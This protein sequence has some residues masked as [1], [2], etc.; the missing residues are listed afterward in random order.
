NRQA[1]V[2]QFQR[3][4]ETGRR[5]A[6]LA[7]IAPGADLAGIL[8]RLA[9]SRGAQRIHLQ[10]SRRIAVPDCGRGRITSYAVRAETAPAP[11]AELPI[12]FPVALAFVD[13]MQV[14]PDPQ[15]V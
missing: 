3:T 12:A 6:V 14:V 8:Q 7:R 4:R 9:R 5:G 13:R 1:A 15:Q 11:D 10:Q 2:R